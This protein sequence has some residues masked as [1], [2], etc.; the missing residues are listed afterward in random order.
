M[1]GGAAQ[2]RR[3]VADWFTRVAATSFWGNSFAARQPVSF[4]G[5]ATTLLPLLDWEVFDRVL[6]AP[7]P[8]D[9]MT[10]RSGRLVEGPA[11]RS[12]TEL[13]NLS[14]AGVSTVVRA[15]E[16]HAPELSVLAAGFETAAQGE[17]HVQLYATPGGTNSYGWHFDFEDVFIIQTLGTKDY[18][19]RDNTVTPDVCLGHPL[20]FTA[21]TRETSPLFTARLIAGD[22]LYIPSRWWHLVKCVEDSLSISTGVMPDVEIQ[23]AHRIPVGWGSRAPAPR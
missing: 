20:D 1:A 13:Q 16:R 3:L 22:W 15:A 21:I 12:K 8:I 2:T 11:P 10:V 5:Q 23:R 9:V 4:A 7:P 18:Y 19:F 17:A 14:R 6:A